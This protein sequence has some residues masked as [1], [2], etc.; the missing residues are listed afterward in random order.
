MLLD[1]ELTRP[2]ND[3]RTIDRRQA[4]LRELLHEAEITGA[5]MDT[6]LQLRMHVDRWDRQRERVKAMQDQCKFCINKSQEITDLA[7]IV[8]IETDDIPTS[9]S[10]QTSLRSIR[11]WT[12]C[13]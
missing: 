4:A 5:P 12:R 2:S 13:T 6:I 11:A 8:T 7:D 9:Y 10:Q 1:P 3:L